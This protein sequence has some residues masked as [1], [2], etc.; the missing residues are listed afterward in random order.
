MF[1]GGNADA[2]S[3]QSAGF[4]FGFLFRSN[5]LHKKIAAIIEK[6]PVLFD[7]LVQA[8]PDWLPVPKSA[9]LNHLAKAQLVRLGKRA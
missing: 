4:W 7:S 3:N 9:R 1:V 8:A 6:S 5:I 2:G